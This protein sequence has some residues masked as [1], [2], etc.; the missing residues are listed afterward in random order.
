MSEGSVAHQR[1]MLVRYFYLAS[2]LSCS[3]WVKET[4]CPPLK[5]APGPFAIYW[6]VVYNANE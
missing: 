6:R 2:V 5:D 4:Q 1:A 3:I